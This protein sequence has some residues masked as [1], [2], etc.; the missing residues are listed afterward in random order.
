MVDNLSEGEKWSVGLFLKLESPT[1][2]RSIHLQSSWGFLLS[3]SL[4]SMSWWGQRF[5]IVT[6]FQC[7]VSYSV[8]V[9]AFFTVFHLAELTISTCLVIK[10]EWNQLH[11][12][13]WEWLTVNQ[14]E[15][16]FRI[17]FL[18]SPLNE[19]VSGGWTLLS[20]LC[21][22]QPRHTYLFVARVCLFD[23]LFVF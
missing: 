3:I 11:L 8:A 18:L 7:E 17:C 4:K 19:W 5:I 6:I 13:M 14:A 10:H 9:E 20:R 1:L 2:L 21:S 22:Q 23:S 12:P 15:D 16:N